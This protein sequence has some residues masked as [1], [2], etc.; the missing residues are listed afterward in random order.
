MLR[1]AVRSN[2]VSSDVATKRM[3]AIFPSFIMANSI[4]SFP[5]LVAALSGIRR[6]QLF[7]TFSKSC[8][9]QLGDRMKPIDTQLT[10]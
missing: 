3:S 4:A 7:R 9:R 2:R 5:F 8:R 1:H 10:A 6:Y